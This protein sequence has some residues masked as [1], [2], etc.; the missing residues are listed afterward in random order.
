MGSNIEWL[1]TQV[2]CGSCPLRVRQEFRDFTEVELEF[3]KGSKRGELHV[4]K[5]GTILEE[6]AANQHLY[7][8]LSGWGFRYKTLSD[9]RR[10]IVNYAMPGD[11]VGLQGTVMGEMQ[12]SVEALSPMV[13]CIFERAKLFMLFEGFP[14]LSFDVTWIASRE[15][16]MLDENLLAVGRRTA[17]EK[18]AY[19]M[20]FL[21][22][23]SIKTGLLGRSGVD[24]PITQQHV[25][26]TLGLSVVHTNRTIRKLVERKLISWTDGGCRIL[27]AE[28]LA[29]IAR[30]EDPIPRP[31]PFL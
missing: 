26:D 13:L 28:R 17:V 24:I 10:Q 18:V 9:G 30:W 20:V 21:L 8:V 31:R 16:C 22:S 1:P 19:L 5:G 25:A 4:A 23:R 2:P 14:Q 3:I 15:E 7:T 12:H 6:G 27:D 11:L 29:L